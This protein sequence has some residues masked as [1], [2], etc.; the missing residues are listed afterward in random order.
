MIADEQSIKKLDD[1]LF[2]AVKSESSSF[3]IDCSSAI[4]SGR[5]V[6]FGGEF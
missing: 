1:S 4:I 3:L 6:V 2:T 5:L